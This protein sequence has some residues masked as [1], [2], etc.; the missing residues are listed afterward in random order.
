MSPTRRIFLNILATY[1]RSL[2]ALVIGIFCGRWSLMALGE[3]D[4]G[5]MGVVGG[6]TVFI[7]F[8]NN[9]L[10]STT[11]RF[12]AVAVGKAGGGEDVEA[13]VEECRQ[14]YSIA[15]VIHTVVPTILMIAGYPIAE[16]TVRN[17]LTIPQDRI[18]DCVWVLR[19]VCLTCYLS[20][21]S[22]PFNAMY[23]AKQYIAELTI[24]QF[25]TSTLNVVFL[26][27]MINH[28]RVWLVPYA[29]WTCVLGLVPSLVIAVRAVCIFPE[30]RFRRGYCLD[31]RKLK[32][33]V[34]YSGW[35]IIGG[36]AMVLRGQGV[37]I[38][39][40][41]F[42][43]PSV[44]ASMHIA[45][46]VNSHAM[47][48]T[49][50]IQNAMAPVINQAVGAGNYDLVR[51][52]SF[53]FC[54]LSMVF[55]LIFLVPLSL[56]LPFIIKL[57]LKSPPDFVVVLCWIM[58]L[59]SFVDKNT[60]GHGMAVMAYGKV[61]WYQI[62][63]GGLNMF[64]I[65]LGWIFCIIGLNVYWVG[66]AMLITWTLLSFGR[67]IFAKVYLQMGIRKWLFEVALPVLVT[68]GISAVIGAT[69]LFLMP[70]SITRLA[71][72]SLIFGSFFIPLAWM[73]I[74]SQG[75]REFIID[76]IR[77]LGLHG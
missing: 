42:F 62:V 45:N 7:A 56:E 41:K 12:Y 20:M 30:C 25:I 22:V 46:T 76:K 66:V 29:V 38:L 37:A 1:G 16:W 31:F 68:G 70:P 44:N 33:I 54:R 6:L 5:L 63:L 11:S 32:E 34:S 27:Y 2:Y 28:P 23:I 4:Y 75:E 48:L 26:Y 73:K 47:T 53:R 43:G 58:L 8:I 50:S 24:Y 49:A 14:W 71:L 17:F 15:I 39:V 60:L 10:G 13:G 21:V 52:L 77:R 64:T 35:M 57:W 72:V 61:K 19:C 67:L 3:V 36:I 74:L 51:T 9:L 69:P 40:N 18:S 55:S 59:I 65:P